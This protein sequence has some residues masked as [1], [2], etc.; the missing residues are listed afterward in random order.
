HVNAVALS[1]HVEAIAEQLALTLYALS[2]LPPAGV[3]PLQA[4]YQGLYELS[5]ALQ[6]D[7]VP[8]HIT[9]VSARYPG[10][11]ASIARLRTLDA[12]ED[13]SLESDLAWAHAQYAT[14]YNAYT[15]LNAQN[16]QGA[17]ATQ[18]THDARAWAA[19]S[20]QEWRQVIAF[21]DYLRAGGM[22]SQPRPR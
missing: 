12:E 20:A 9:G 19:Q 6:G 5:S 2:A 4:L 13:T 22:T 10:L 1:V 14:A 21:L 7:V 3:A 15:R 8:H 11:L 17:Q 16:K 18:Q